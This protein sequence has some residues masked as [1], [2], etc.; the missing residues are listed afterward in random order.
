[1]DKKPHIDWHCD[2]CGKDCANP[3]SP[4]VHNIADGGWRCSKCDSA[5]D[6]KKKGN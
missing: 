2:D 4:I 1:M 3:P 5:N 6:K